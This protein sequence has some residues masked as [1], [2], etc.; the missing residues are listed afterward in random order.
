[1]N[2]VYGLMAHRSRIEHTQKIL[3][4]LDRA[5]VTTIDLDDHGPWWTAERTWQALIHRAMPM[6]GVGTRFTELLH[7]QRHQT[8]CCL[9]Q[10]DIV[11]AEDFAPALE[12]LI[13]QDNAVHGKLL[14]RRPLV[15]C[16][17]GRVAPY[18]GSFWIERIDG[19][20]GPA[21]CMRVDDVESLL[22][23]S[24]KHVR[25]DQRSSDLRVGLWLE[26]QKR[27]SLRPSPS[28][29]QHQQLPSIAG[30]RAH[31]TQPRQAQ[32]F[33][34]LSLLD[35]DW[36]QG[37]TRE[38]PKIGKPDAVSIRARGMLWRMGATQPD[39]PPFADQV[40]LIDR[41]HG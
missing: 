1:M 20:N 17:M 27:S 41:M 37:L 8:W 15:L 34:G 40:K 23:W 33:T 35:Y 32:S 30:S 11:L 12:R 6:S 4:D 5:C 31:P 25:D 22:S 13:E 18:D 39:D 14:R 10:D 16:N 24:L 9:L 7:E 21:L 36:T 29:V 38:L 26:A 19:V 3:H 2:V 28:W